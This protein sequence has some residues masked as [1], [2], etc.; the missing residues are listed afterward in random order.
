MELVISQKY[1]KKTAADSQP[2][3]RFVYEYD[4]MNQLIKEEDKKEGS[5]RTYEY[6]AGGNLLKY[7]KYIVKDGKQTLVMTD[8]YAYGNTWKDQMTSYNGNPVTYDDMG[9]PLTY[10]ISTRPT[11]REISQESLTVAETR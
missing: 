10:S 11:C 9:N 8:S 4:L 1:W 2:V 7:K 5:I 3:S 6:D